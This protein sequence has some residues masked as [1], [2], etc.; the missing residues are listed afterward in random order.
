MNADLLPSP[1][2][3]ATSAIVEPLF[4]FLDLKAQFRSLRGEVLAAME[5]V[6]DS[7]HFIL[8]PEVAGLEKE[9]ATLT[10]STFAV[11]CAS[12]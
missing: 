3:P 6:M 11:A 8:G 5:A 1:A 9:I 4:P 7:Q 12:G 2:V 10:G